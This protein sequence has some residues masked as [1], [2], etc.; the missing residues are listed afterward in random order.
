MILGFT[1]TRRGMTG[2]QQ[3][4]V[5]RLIAQVAGASESAVVGLHGDCVGA[6]VDFHLL[7]RRVGLQ[8]TCRPCTLD[9]YRAHTDAR[10]IAPPERPM[11]RNRKIVADADFV[12]GCP[13]NREIIKRGS[14]TWATIGMA[15][16]ARKKLYVVYPMGDF[17]HVACGCGGFFQGEAYVHAERCER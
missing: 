3:R 4:T 9:D 7:C 15:L 2:A 14:G 5:A 16:S 10:I 12:M 11:A 17:L 1:G 13:P 8:V 6:D